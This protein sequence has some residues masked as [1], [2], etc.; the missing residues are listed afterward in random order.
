MTNL[1]SSKVQEKTAYP[2]DQ[3]HTKS[4]ITEII[5]TLDQIWEGS[6]K[7]SSHLFLEGIT[8]AQ[9][10][11]MMQV[12][13]SELAST[14]AQFRAA[15][16]TILDIQHA[17]GYSKQ[18]MADIL[19]GI[20]PEIESFCD[21]WMKDVSLLKRLELQGNGFTREQTIDLVRHCKRESK[22]EK[23]EALK[24]HADNLMTIL[25]LAKLDTSRLTKRLSGPAK[26]FE[27][28]LDT[29]KE[30][31]GIYF[32]V[33]DTL[34]E[35]EWAETVSKPYP[36]VSGEPPREAQMATFLINLLSVSDELNFSASWDRASEQERQTYIKHLLNR[37]L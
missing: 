15:T 25:K 22:T 2:A 33:M 11:R 24:Q 9:Q 17:N 6:S 7:Y 4:D 10:E 1:I 14:L 26:Q 20:G 16:Y 23:L 31:L 30:R 37:P 18:E 29:I 32:S 36:S 3:E 8:P 19:E 12:A 13:A 27:T 28:A 35:Q 21:A 34:S 5:K